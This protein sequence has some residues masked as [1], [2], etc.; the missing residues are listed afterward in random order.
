MEVGVPV[1]LELDFSDFSELLKMCAEGS[2]IYV[3]KQLHPS[4]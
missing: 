1:K 2:S 3:S 4:Q